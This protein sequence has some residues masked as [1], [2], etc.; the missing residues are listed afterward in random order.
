MTPAQYMEPNEAFAQLGRIKLTEVTLAD[1]C[2]QVSDLAKRTI[3]GVT[4]A[5]ITLV[6]GNQA[7]TAASTGSLALALDLAQYKLRHGPCLRAATS[8]FTQS[9]SDMASESRWPRWT[10]AAGKAGAKSSL[11][12]GLPLEEAIT[13][14]LNLYSTEADAFD[15]DAVALAQTFASYANVA[16]ANAYLVAAKQQLMDHLAIAG[17]SRAVIEQAKG[18]V[19]GNLHCS[20]DRAFVVLKKMSQDTNRKLRD[21]AADLVARAHKP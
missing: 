20:A 2:E 16:M 4:E 17:E 14:A 9:I 13:G 21:V 19:M 1:V 10:A 7:H 15:D 6:Q 12:I 5:S 8:T 18:I 11:S 3:P